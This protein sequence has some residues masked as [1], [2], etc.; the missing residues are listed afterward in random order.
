MSKL[1]NGKVNHSRVAARTGLSRAD[2]KR[3]LKSSVIGSLRS[4]QTPIK[5]VVHAWRTDPHYLT[6]AGLPKRLSIAGPGKS[7][8]S[9]VREYGGDIPSRAIL[10]ELRCMGAIAERRGTIA[11]HLFLRQQQPD[12]IL[13]SVLPALIDGIRIAATRASPGA[14]QFMH[15]LSLPVQSE[16]DMTIA[17]ERC[18]TSVKAMLDGLAKSL[19]SPITA[20]RREKRTASSLVLTVLLAER[21]SQ[22]VKLGD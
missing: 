12:R 11:L 13:A 20:P 6:R 19:G 3:L 7:F 8:S 18:S 2:V 5:R 17:R 4:D 21:R 1:R 22:R 15:R 9:L 14:G 10:D 16:I